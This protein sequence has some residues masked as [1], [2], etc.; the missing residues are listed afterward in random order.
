MFTDEE[1]LIDHIEYQAPIG[2]SDHVC[3]V[4]SLV[5][6]K[7][8]DNNEETKRNFWKGNYDEMNKHRE[9]IDCKHYFLGETVE[10]MWNKFLAKMT[11]LVLKHVPLKSNNSQ[12]QLDKWIS[13][14]TIRM[15]KERGNAWRQY[16]DSSTSEHYSMYNQF[17]QSSQTNP[18][19]S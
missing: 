2:L 8:D 5:M 18:Q 17:E 9:T 4:W 10:T 14:S 6:V 7:T 1:N 15:M 11:A 16:R 3:L 12:H 13:N 19:G